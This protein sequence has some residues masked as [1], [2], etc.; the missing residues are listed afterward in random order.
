MGRVEV[1]KIGSVYKHFICFAASHLLLWFAWSSSLISLFSASSLIFF[2]WFLWAVFIYLLFVDVSP[3]AALGRHLLCLVMWLDH[4]KNMTK[5][6]LSHV[7]WVSMGGR[8]H[9]TITIWQAR[10]KPFLGDDSW[11]TRQVVKPWRS[12]KVYKQDV[13][14]TRSKCIS[15]MWCLQGVSRPSQVRRWTWKGI[16]ER[17]FSHLFIIYITLSSS[18]CVLG[19]LYYRSQ[20]FNKFTIFLHKFAML[21][22][23]VR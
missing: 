23:S 21:L 9:G 11:K 18:L 15:K 20:R 17:S 5:H 22:F 4:R 3:W 2:I 12:P 1:W 16:N 7:T 19:C 8:N 14:S 6:G 13:K 10:D